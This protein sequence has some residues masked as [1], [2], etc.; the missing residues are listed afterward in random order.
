MTFEEYRTKRQAILDAQ[1]LLIRELA[2]LDRE[3]HQKQEE[4]YDNNR[5]YME[6]ERARD[7]R[8]DCSFVQG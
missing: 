6:D 5:S 2:L 4:S 7:Q 3:Y 8:L 1:S